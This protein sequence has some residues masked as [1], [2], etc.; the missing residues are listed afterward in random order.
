MGRKWRDLEWPNFGQLGGR[1][2]TDRPVG[3][4]AVILGPK[5]AGDRSGKTPFRPVKG[6]NLAA[7]DVTRDMRKM[8]NSIGCKQQGDGV[9]LGCCYFAKDGV[10]LE[11]ER[12][13]IGL[14]ITDL[15][16]RLG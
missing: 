13:V 5:P 3:R 12:G 9:Q 4:L 1:K 6:L 16:A 10:Q 8:M 14:C 2:R 7:M 15:G 11:E